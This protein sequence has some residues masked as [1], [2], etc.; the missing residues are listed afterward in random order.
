VPS[1]IPHVK[2]HQL[3]FCSDQSCSSPAPPPLLPPP[4]RLHSCGG[5]AVA[6][7]QATHRYVG[8]RNLQLATMSKVCT[9]ACPPS[10]AM[11]PQR[12]DLCSHTTMFTSLNEFFASPAAKKQANK[13]YHCAC[14]IRALCNMPTS[15]PPA[16]S[17]FRHAR[18][19]P[20]NPP[21]Q[22][23][24]LPNLSHRQVYHAL[25]DSP[26]FRIAMMFSLP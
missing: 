15:A 16:F 25:L 22:T 26:L 12:T 1:V 10:N 21:Y 19:G 11:L 24:S 13:D 3:T 17:H 14:L 18:A 6:K 20:R 8:Q 23:S 2:Q 5:F 9:V 4:P 7:E